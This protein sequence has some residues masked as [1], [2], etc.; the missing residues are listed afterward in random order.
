MHARCRNSYRGTMALYVNNLYSD[1][2]V[3]AC[4]HPAPWRCQPR[5]GLWGA[6]CGI[7]NWVVFGT[8][9]SRIRAVFVSAKFRIS[10]QPRGGYA[11]QRKHG[12]CYRESTEIKR[13]TLSTTVGRCVLLIVRRHNSGRRGV[14]RTV[15]RTRKSRLGQNLDFVDWSSGGESGLGCS[16]WRPD[17]V[18][19]VVGCALVYGAR[20]TVVDC[21]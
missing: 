21:P 10:I 8:V 9:G 20:T 15:P 7:P 2:W 19:G 3:V 5:C 1:Y 6:G 4:A 12:A 16:S 18:G 17:A 14:G 13:P 11:A